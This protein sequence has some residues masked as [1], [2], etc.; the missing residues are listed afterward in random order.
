[1]IT[2]LLIVGVL[3]IALAIAV[4]FEVAERAQRK[5]VKKCSK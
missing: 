1:M 3:V 2:A 5:G 4:A